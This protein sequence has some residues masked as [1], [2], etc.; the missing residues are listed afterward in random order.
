MEVLVESVQML[1]VWV[2]PYM[3]TALKMHRLL[4]TSIKESGLF[5]SFTIC[6]DVLR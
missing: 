5:K 1:Y 6:T 2:I 4:I 3:T